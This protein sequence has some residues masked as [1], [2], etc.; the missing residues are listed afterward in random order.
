MGLISLVNDD[1]VDNNLK[2]IFVFV[3]NQQSIQEEHLVYLFCYL[4]MC[5]TYYC[6]SE[7]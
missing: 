1:N 3:Y 4:L 2:E 6:M 5:L 7:K